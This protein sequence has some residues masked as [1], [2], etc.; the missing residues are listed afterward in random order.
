MAETEQ[1]TTLQDTVE[2]NEQCYLVD[3]ME[4]ISRLNK[5]GRTKKNSYKRITRLQSAEP[6]TILSKINSRPYVRTFFNIK[7]HQVAALVPKIRIFKVHLTEKEVR[8]KLVE[9]KFEDSTSN[10]SIANI[11]KSK[12][13]RGDG[14]GIQS[15]E[16]ETQGK[17]P[18]EG[19]LVKCTMVLQFQNIEMLVDRA[20]PGSETNYLDLIWRHTKYHRDIDPRTGEVIPSSQRF[21]HNYFKIMATVGWAMPEGSLGAGDADL[22]KALK[23][24]TQ[25]IFLSLMRHNIDFKQDG[26]ISLTVTYQGAIQGIL[27]SP[28]LDV[29]YVGDYKNIEAE[30]EKNKYIMREAREQLEL[31]EQEE[32]NRDRASTAREEAMENRPEEKRV[33]SSA[34]GEEGRAVLERLNRR[35]PA[36]QPPSAAGLPPAPAGGAD[37]ARRT[38]RIFQKANIELKA[39][40]RAERYSRI[41]TALYQKGRLGH[42]DLNKN[43]ID[44]M[45]ADPEERVTGVRE[46]ITKNQFDVSDGSTGDQN[47]E[48]RE[49]LEQQLVEADRKPSAGEGLELLK[50]R[51][52][53]GTAR[54]TEAAPP[55]KY[56]INFFFLGDLFEI[57]AE[58]HEVARKSPS[59]MIIPEVR[60]V[61]GP[62][63]Y[64]YPRS[65]D[66]THTIINL[67]DVPIS[68]KLFEIWFNR[69]VVG[70]RL[71]SYPLKNFIRDLITQLVLAALGDA[72]FKGMG[73]RKNMVGI[74][75]LLVP[76][77]GPK[78]KN[79]RIATGD[80]AIESLKSN[81]FSQYAQQGDAPPRRNYEAY[82]HY[83]LIYG[84]NESPNYL[85][86]REI[87]EDF[88]NGIYHFLIGADRGLLK[89][90]KFS[91]TDIPALAAARLTSEDQR[92]SQLRDKYN[93]TVSLIGNPFFTP[94]QKIY[95]N[96]SL[97][98]FG[99]TRSR[100]SIARELGIGGYFDV[101]KVRS[102]L[103]RG[104]Y[105]TDLECVWQTFGVDRKAAGAPKVGAAAKKTP[106]RDLEDAPVDAPVL[107]PEEARAEVK[108]KIPAAY[109]PPP[110]DDEAKAALRG[111][112]FKYQSDKEL[113]E[114]EDIQDYA[115][116]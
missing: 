30:I 18:A 94:G 29:L 4:E 37:Y 22:R 116:Y 32:R 87:E 103:K 19:A 34:S 14:V 93:A 68:L 99:S 42:I 58:L 51:L 106:P 26:T 52:N 59:K 75:G 44:S 113:G 17:N 25:T 108:Y 104:G 110:P 35:G 89:N 5:A 24:C 70:P 97:G 57:L 65:E 74:Q 16:V 78:G 31:A 13:G 76:G 6:S 86:S 38:I 46:L 100:N 2:F 109:K 90:I 27:S 67:A 43:Q 12:Y 9:L 60:Y 92:E 81:V 61:L 50:E 72:C 83:L 49:A 114:L 20:N 85:D 23:E 66:G 39:K 8:T 53:F 73:V 107:D 101:I 41:L 115:R 96:P 64:V 54:D 82:K 105:N 3:H 56:R 36:V 40:Q 11:T 69:N 28:G 71:D 45:M 21:N 88:K 111:K 79:H 112:G 10:K 47:Q 63:K 62:F 80:V 55:E 1:G 84:A 98:G 91:R 77:K 7:P 102:T 95:I 15:F 33:F 48:T